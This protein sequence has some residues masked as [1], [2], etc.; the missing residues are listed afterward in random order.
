VRRS[1]VADAC[2]VVG[3]ALVL[4][5]ALLPWVR[6]GP[7]RSLH[8]HALVD[9]VVALGNNVPGLSSARLTIA[10]Y[11]VPACGTLT[12]IALGLFGRRAVATRVVASVTVVVVVLV[13]IAFGR[14]VGFG[15][16]GTGPLVA[17]VGAALVGLAAWWPT[18]A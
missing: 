6:R 14:V 3:G 16:L 17:L 18:A 7:G 12:W 11:L 9:A 4:V 8:G 10:W 13:D 5:S 1:R 15:D 2:V